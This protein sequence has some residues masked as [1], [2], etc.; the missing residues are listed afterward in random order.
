MA[1]TRKGESEG[2]PRG[3][4]DPYQRVEVFKCSVIFLCNLEDGLVDP[5]RIGVV[6][7]CASAGYGISAAATDPRIKSV[8]GISP[9]CF[10][11]LVREGLRGSDGAINPDHLSNRLADAAK[12]RLELGF[13]FISFML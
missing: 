4:E 1:S 6:G 3:L 13:P 7:I 9:M 10:G 5:N 8:A 11:T 12:D 2:Q